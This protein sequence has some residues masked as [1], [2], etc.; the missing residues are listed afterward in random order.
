MADIY[1]VPQVFNALRFDMDMSPYPAI[2]SVY[3]RCNELDAF[4]QAHPDNQRDK[5][6]T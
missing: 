6:A 3:N 5:P 2:M 1:L 4:I